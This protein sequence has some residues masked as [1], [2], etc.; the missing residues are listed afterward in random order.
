MVVS[1]FRLLCGSLALIGLPQTSAGFW[2]LHMFLLT[3]SL[4]P[5][6]QPVSN[7]FLL[8]NLASPL[9]CSALLNLK[10]RCCPMVSKLAALS[11]LLWTALNLV[12]DKHGCGTL[13]CN[14][15]L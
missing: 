15:V 4:P 10:A 6:C 11:A 12:L 1:G 2:F 3:S 8:P 7:H 13:P 5:Q 9:Y 14:H